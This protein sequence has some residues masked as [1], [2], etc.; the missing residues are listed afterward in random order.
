M[1]KYTLNLSD[2]V[3]TLS[4]QSMSDM[5]GLSFDYIDDMIDEVIPK[6]YSNRVSILDNGEERKSL[7]KKIIEHYWE[8]EICTYTPNDFILRL[9]RKLKEI[10][11]YYNQLYNSTLLEL[12]P[13]NDV[14]YTVNGTTS[15]TDKTT[16]NNTALYT[17]T[18]VNTLNR[19]GSDIVDGKVDTDTTENSDGNMHGSKQVADSVN[20][21][22]SKN[23]SIDVKDTVKSS[24][25]DYRNDTP[26]D[27]VT[28]AGSLISDSYLTYYGA[29][30]PKNEAFA[31]KGSL[32]SGDDKIEIPATSDKVNESDLNRHVDYSSESANHTTNESFTNYGEKREGKGTLDTTTKDTTTYNTTFKNTLV[33]DTKDKVDNIRD[34]QHSGSDDKHFKGKMSTDSYSKRMLE[35]RETMLNIDKMVIDELKELFFMIY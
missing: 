25:W 13:F 21:K 4:N 28:N 26:Y 9:N 29:R 10:M 19:T 23:S 22:T 1:A 16:D 35:F 11:P 31:L 24:E 5:S 32:G 20:N 15:A 34:F 17:G 2:V 30:E 27:K 18:D 8:Y 3:S 14:D 6:L 12:N 33:K 7:C